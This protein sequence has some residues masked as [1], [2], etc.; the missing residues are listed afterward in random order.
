MNKIIWTSILLQIKQSW[1]RPMYRFCIVIQ[2]CL[3][4]IMT[5]MMFKVSA[6]KNFMSFVVLGTGMLTLWSSIA[7]SSAGDIDRERRMGTLKNIMSTPTDY[8]I[9]IFS[10]TLGNTLLGSLPMVIIFVITAIFF[11]DLFYLANP[12]LFIISFFEM[13]VSFMAISLIFAA[14]FTLS[15][16]TRI[17]MNCMEFPIYILCGFLIPIENLPQWIRWLSW[18]LSPTW[19]VKIIIMTIEGVNNIKEYIVISII[20]L[21]LTIVYFISAYIILGLVEKR[22]RITAT[23]E[24]S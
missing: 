19:A 15:R 2:P 13:I 9:I 21:I 12:I 23:M 6:I 1:A 4:I 5:Y 3:Y 8:R 17:F 11:K 10:K 24:I 22:V 7:F 18:A 16:K 20:L 14:L